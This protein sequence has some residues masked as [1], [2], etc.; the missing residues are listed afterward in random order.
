MIYF[1]IRWSVWLWEQQFVLQLRLRLLRGRGVQGRL[2][3]WLDGRRWGQS[4]TGADDGEGEGARAVQ[5]NRKERSAEETVSSTTYLTTCK[6]HNSHHTASY[7]HVLSIH[8]I[9]VCKQLRASEM[10]EYFLSGYVALDR[11]KMG[12]RSSITDIEIIVSPL[13]N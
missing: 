9:C 13:L 2:R 4:S 1:L 7:G 3:R 6:R 10:K 11:Q 12:R 5:P 8:C